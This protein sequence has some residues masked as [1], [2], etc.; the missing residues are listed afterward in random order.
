MMSQGERKMK[1]FLGLNLLAIRTI[2]EVFDQQIF[3]ITEDQRL[4]EIVE[5][6]LPS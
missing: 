6:C 1:F 2:E 5:M 3:G 4:S